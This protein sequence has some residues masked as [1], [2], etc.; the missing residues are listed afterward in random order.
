MTINTNKPL[1]MI[2][3]DE[4]SNILLL[5]RTLQ[6]DYTTICCASGLE[7]LK[8]LKKQQ[9]EIILLDVMMPGLNGYEVCAQI[10]EN[11][12]TAHIPV[13]F[14]S[15]S[16]TLDARLKG[17]NAGGDDYLEKPVKLSILLKKIELILINKKNKQQLTEELDHVQSGFMHA[18]N[19]GEEF[20]QVTHFIEQCLAVQ[21]HEQLLCTFFKAMRH[22]E[23]HSA[24]QIRIEKKTI[25]LNSDGDCLPLEKE[26]LLKAQF[27]G[28]ILEFGSRLFIS[29]GQFSLLVKDAPVDDPDRIQRLQEHLCAIARICDYRIKA[30]ENEQHVQSH[31]EITT[32]L[33]NTLLSLEHIIQTLDDNTENNLR[34]ELQ[35]MIKQLTQARSGSKRD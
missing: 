33:N 35:D 26:L 6:S 9:P 22:F 1:I 3:D 15:A 17:Y 19:M 27:D 4:P 11:N 5:E 24:A 12:D 7:C 14:I 21:T 32:L 30:I 23:L 8:Q 28:R 18:L 34:G 16:D 10:K 2:V 13:F 31:K 20:G 29:Y 25:T